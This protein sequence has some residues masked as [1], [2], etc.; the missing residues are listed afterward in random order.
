MRAMQDRSK[1][2]LIL[3]IAAVPFGFLADQLLKVTP[4]GINV[5]LATLVLA[6]VVLA[7]SRATGTPLTGGG[8]WFVLP[9]LVFAGLFAL[10]D[11]TAL[12]AFNLLALLC[13]LA[14]LV[15]RGAAGRVVVAGI[16]NYVKALLVAGVSALIGVLPLALIVRWRELNLTGNARAIGRVLLGLVI[17]APLLLIF[18]ALFVAA[19]AGFE[20]LLRDLF[21][22]TIDEL[23][24]RVFFT[25]VL[26]WMSAGAL[27]QL[28][29]NTSAPGAAPVGEK[30]RLLSLGIVEI[31]VVLGLLNV[32]FAAFVAT[33][34]RYFFGGAALVLDT[35]DASNRLT[36]AEYARRG[37]FELVTVAALVLVVL[38]AANWVTRHDEPRHAQIFR[39]LAG[40][41][42]ALL[43]VIMAS[44]LHRMWTYTRVYGLTELRVYTTV[45]M[46]WLAP[47]FAWFIA[48]TL[49]G[50]GDRFAFGMAVSGLAAL[51]V[52]NLMNPLDLI[53]RTNVA[54]IV[55]ANA[56]AAPAIEPDG[57]RRAESL[58]ATY[59]ARLAS[60][61]AD[62]VPPLM[63]SLALLEPD[64]RCVIA[65]G[66]VFHYDRYILPQTKNG[67]WRGLNY[68]R[69]T[70]QRWLTPEWRDDLE[71]IACPENV[72]LES[73]L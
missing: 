50:R 46:L 14:M 71:K 54:R 42:I 12:N 19:D 52:L 21:D 20:Q 13:C 6:G 23:I 27:W 44:A 40:T 17:A 11:T 59:L 53:A 66:L 2:A 72:Y 60:Q 26:T 18:G 62:A 61:S 22:I 1:A 64:E 4:W 32:L 67:D 7:A 41:L 31:G 25:G 49:R 3:L 63:A 29:L 33:Q 16:G 70:A 56:A 57:L 48:S 15:A 65:A 5:M 38:L 73:G 51:L 55:A 30:R 8:R 37:F 35:A 43:F 68:A 10:R 47:V 45:F 9:A 39:L 28:F 24:T 69:N 34:A 36:F 58:D